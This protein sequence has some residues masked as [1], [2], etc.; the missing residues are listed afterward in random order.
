M[1]PDATVTLSPIPNPRGHD[2]PAPAGDNDRSAPRA[3]FST[4]LGQYSTPPFA[5]WPPAAA[6]IKTPVA[7][8]GTQTVQPAE[9]GRRQGQR[10]GRG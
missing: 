9:R 1:K 3:P 7:G 5:P 6:D 4:L 10:R 8:A 2:G